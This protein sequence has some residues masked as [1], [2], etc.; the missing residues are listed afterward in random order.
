MA[1]APADTLGQEAEARRCG[2][3]SH[4][5]KALGFLELWKG[6]RSSTDPAE[7]T[8]HATTPNLGEM[9]LSSEGVAGSVA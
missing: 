6:R 4:R 5:E 9:W 2:W 8:G 1:G 7:S 3:Q